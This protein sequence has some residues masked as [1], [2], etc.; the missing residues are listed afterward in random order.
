[1]GHGDIIGQGDDLPKPTIGQNQVNGVSG[2]NQAQYGVLNVTPTGGGVGIFRWIEHG[3]EPGVGDEMNDLD[4]VAVLARRIQLKW[5]VINKEKRCIQE[6]GNMPYCWT[7]RPC[8]G[9]Q[10]YIYAMFDERFL[11]AFVGMRWDI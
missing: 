4:R 6:P 5:Y 1:M 9:Y 10:R 7:L 11:P 3:T 2:A 8:I